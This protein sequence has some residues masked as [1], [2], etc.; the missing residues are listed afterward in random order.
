[1]T[2]LPAAAGDL[3]RKHPA[4]WKAYSA[5]GEA[6]S[7]AGPLDARSRRLVKLALAIG[8]QSEGAV[9]SHARQALDEG[10][11]ANEIRH[12]A[13]LAVTTLGFPKAIA[14]LSWIDDVT[15]AEKR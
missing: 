8:A 14:A 10:L 2:K 13:L 5:L 7:G 11:S 3:A 1:M 9:H 4:V 12:A 15:D 6:V